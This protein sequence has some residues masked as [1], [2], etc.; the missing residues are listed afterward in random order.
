M[1]R[2]RGSLSPQVSVSISMLPPCGSDFNSHN[3]KLEYYI[4]TKVRTE[5]C[6]QNP[7]ELFSH[8]QYHSIEFMKKQ[9]SPIY[10]QL[11]ITLISTNVPWIL[12]LNSTSENQLQFFSLIQLYARMLHCMGINRMCLLFYLLF[13]IQYKCPTIKYAI[14]RSHKG[15]F[16]GK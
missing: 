9:F 15:T 3:T 16:A 5:F 2:R 4:F 14:F 12:N 8:G 10:F 11:H 13:K 7:Q 1:N 6:A